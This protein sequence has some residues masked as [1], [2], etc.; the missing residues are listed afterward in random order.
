MAPSPVND[1]P[2]KEPE[3]QNTGVDPQRKQQQQTDPQVTELR[4]FVD[5]DEDLE[6]RLEDGTKAPDK[7]PN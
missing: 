4:G 3:K 7:A 5:P 2:G 6:P 1:K